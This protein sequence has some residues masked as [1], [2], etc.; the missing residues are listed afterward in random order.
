MF[1]I[2]SYLALKITNTKELEK[3][4]LEIRKSQASSH[5]IKTNQ[6]RLN[7]LQPDQGF[8]KHSNSLDNLN[9]LINARNGAIG[10]NNAG[11]TEI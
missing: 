3:Y 8:Y 5:L 4:D 10:P 2:L 11:N 6:S 9:G 1:I 7:F